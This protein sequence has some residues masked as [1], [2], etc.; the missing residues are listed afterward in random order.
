M[1]WLTGFFQ[2][3]CIEATWWFPFQ[4]ICCT[5]ICTLLS[6]IQV[7]FGIL[8]YIWNCSCVRLQILLVWLSNWRWGILEITFPCYYEN[9][10]VHYCVQNR[11]H[12]LAL[13]LVQPMLF[14]RP[15]LAICVQVVCLHQAA[16]PMLCIHFFIMCGTGPSYPICIIWSC[17]KHLASWH[18][19]HR[20]G[21]LKCL[22]NARCEHIKQWAL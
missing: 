16:V 17:Q 10:N 19:T 3:W 15:I 14:L 1:Q 5:G 8:A 4:W 22:K 2:A 9:P 7:L 18:F 12:S 20:K 13:I 21:K 11:G 6:T